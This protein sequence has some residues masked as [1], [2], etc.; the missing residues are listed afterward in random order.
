MDLVDGE[1]HIT[2]NDKAKIVRIKTNN[3][4]EDND[5]ISADIRIWITR[6]V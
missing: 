3:D 4:G 5:M 1:F 2:E 6:G